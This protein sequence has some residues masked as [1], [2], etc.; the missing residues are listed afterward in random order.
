MQLFLNFID[1]QSINCTLVSLQTTLINLQ[2]KLYFI[3]YKLITLCAD[4]VF[5][6]STSYRSCKP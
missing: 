3:E 4:S 2:L 6:G 1:S 5:G